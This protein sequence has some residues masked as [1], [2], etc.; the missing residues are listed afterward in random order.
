M[1]TVA[2]VGA[3][4]VGTFFAAHAAE[5]GHDVTLC[6][7]RALPDGVEVDSHLGGRVLRPD[8]RVV[9]DPDAIHGPA[10]WVLL[11]TKAHQ[12]DGAAGWLRAL[13]GPGTRV[14]VAQNGVEHHE[15]VAPHVGDAVVLPAVVYCGVEVVAPG[16]VVHRTN[17]FLIVDDDEHGRALRALYEPAEAGIRLSDRLVDDR[18]RKLAANVAANGLTALTRRRM[19]IFRDPAIAAVATDLIDECVAVGRAEGAQLDDGLAEAIVGG[20]A[21]MPEDSGTSMLYDLESGKPLEHDALHGA[22]VRVAARHGIDVPVTRTVLA[23]LG[24]LS[25]T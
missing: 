13:V 14:V 8:L 5:A 1:S 22:V 20:M 25:P 9:T 24:A 19:G 2:V 7:R 15:R 4:A 17:G 6:S 3:G 16:R 21:A 18:W 11:A 23:L 12:T 10:D